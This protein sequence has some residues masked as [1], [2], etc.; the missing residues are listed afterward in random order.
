M[1]KIFFIILLI[2]IFFEIYVREVSPVIHVSDK[3]IG[4]K[5]KKNL[6]LK[7]EQKDLLGKKYNVH[8][9]T[10]ENGARFYGTKSNADLKILVIGDSFTNMPYASNDKMWFSVFADKFKKK[11]N[12]NIYIET[13]GAGGYG[14]LQQ[15][16]L[17]EKMYKDFDPNFVVMQIC[18]NDFMDNTYEWVVKNRNKNQFLRSPY[19]KNDL[20]FYDKSLFSIFYK[21]I[22][23]ENIRLV[24]RIDLFISITLYKIYYLV[25]KKTSYDVDIEIKNNSIKITDR[26]FKKIKN[27]FND[28]DVFVINCSQDNRYPFNQWSKIALNNEMIPLNI[29]N[30][31]KYSD[32]I[33]YKDGG[34]FNELGNYQIGEIVGNKIIKFYNLNK[35]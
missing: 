1:K 25:N 18:N 33:F 15:F 19:L 27:F 28:K 30:S 11:T 3:H 34:H 32:N 31:F 2:F 7:I 26:I 35:N 5:L 24:S 13:I 14:N 6:D 21:S 22:F 23:Y 10:N 8:F 9:I 20:I 12:S 4:W 29:F 16:L 17:L